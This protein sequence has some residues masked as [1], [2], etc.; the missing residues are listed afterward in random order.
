M[1]LKYIHDYL[2]KNA[3]KTS[4]D[5]NIL[6][7]PLALQPS[8]TEKPEQFDQWLKSIFIKWNDDVLRIGTN[9]GTMYDAIFYCIDQKFSLLTADQQKN[10]IIMLCTDS[11]KQLNKK[12]KKINMFQDFG[13]KKLGWKKPT[14]TYLLKKQQTSME[15]IRFFADYFD[16]NIIIVDS[17]DQMI[18]CHYSD[19]KFCPYKESI[20]LIRTQT[21]FDPLIS[22]DIDK[23]CWN[24]NDDFF[25]NFIKTY[26]NKFVCPT[27]SQTGKDATTRTFELLKLRELKSIDEEEIQDVFNKD[28]DLASLQKYSKKY[29]IPI[30][31]GKKF[32]TKQM[33]K[34]HLKKIYDKQLENN[35]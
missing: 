10:H 15:V 8:T 1:D 3:D 23:H 26:K 28:M 5:I 2:S 22:D 32:R 17:D 31:M 33:L 11:Y 19:N 12:D 29:G 30:K 21:G 9:N 34:D 18:Q 16:I 6:N 25:T 7:Y 13:Y 14:L 4:T 35:K 27:Y 24:Y 20:I